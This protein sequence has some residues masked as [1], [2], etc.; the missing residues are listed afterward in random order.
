AH[1]IKNPLAG[2]SYVA[3]ILKREVSFEPS[4][5]ELVQAMFSEIN[6]LN[7]LIEDL[8]LYG[9]PARLAL[10]PQYVHKIWED[11]VHLSKEQ[12]D[13]RNLALAWDLDPAVPP[14]PL[15]G[16]RM[17]Q[18]FLNLLKNAIEAT[19]AGG[20]IVVRTRHVTAAGRP[21]RPVEWPPAAPPDGADGWVEIAIE[22]TG[23]GIPEQDRDRIFEL[24][25]TTK[26][27]GS[28]LGLPICRR[29][30]E[31]HGG[32]ISLASRPGAGSAFTIRLPSSGAGA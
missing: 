14:I 30:V 25:Y 15:D 10:A 13:A 5:R 28:G 32:T 6:R 26:P 19:P 22:D 27:S 31:E 4:H 2:I 18:V 17:R 16:N 20:R 3:Q 23:Q 8:L 21:R 7:G 24:F 29:I 9:R 12:L 1:E 11:I